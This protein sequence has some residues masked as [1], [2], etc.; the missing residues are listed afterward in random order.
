MNTAEETGLSIFTNEEFGQVRVVMRDGEP[1]FVASDVA[2][3]LGYTNPSRSVHDHCK[4]AELFRTTHEV[5][6]EINPRGELIIPESDVYALI[7]RSNL[8]KAEAFRD[9]VCREVLPSIRKAGSYSVE[10]V[11]V[12]KPA[13][14]TMDILM[15]TKV[16]LETAG[17]ERN[18]VAIGM[19]N[20]GRKLTGLDALTLA[21]VA[22]ESPVARQALNV[23]EI[24]KAI[25][26]DAEKLQPLAVAINKALCAEGYQVKSPNGRY[27]PTDKGMEHAFMQDVGKLHSNGT[28]VKQ[29]KWYTSILPLVQKAMEETD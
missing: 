20:A 15:M 12:A 28:P 5:V 26:P 23:R 25:Y 7:F 24:A 17:L 18:Q 21:G 13:P 4:Y 16:I 22:L 19:N 9:W 29:L 6:L 3:A 8:P 27:E 11:E 1:W 10:D 2:K 14:S